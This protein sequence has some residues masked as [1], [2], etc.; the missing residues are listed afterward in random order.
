[1]KTPV[2]ITAVHLNAAYTTDRL[3]GHVEVSVEIDG[4]WVKI[5]SE[6]FDPSGFHISN[7]CEGR[8]IEAAE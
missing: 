1:M 4:K 5:I 8:G 3:M 6:K 2:T 7:I